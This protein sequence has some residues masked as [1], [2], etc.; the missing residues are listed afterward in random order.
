MDAR[1]IVAAVW[2]RLV[3]SGR[4]PRDSDDQG[5]G[6]HGRSEFTFNQAGEAIRIFTPSRYRAVNGHF[7]PTPWEGR[8]GNYAERSWMWIP[9]DAEVSWQIAGSWQ[10]WWRGRIVSVNPM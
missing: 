7:E 2:R 8:F 10:P 1:G 3:A 9:L 5:F 6:N 4:N